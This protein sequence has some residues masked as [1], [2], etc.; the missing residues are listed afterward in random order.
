M[1]KTCLG[2]HALD[3]VQAPA[4]DKSMMRLLVITLAHSEF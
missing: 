1:R 4:H 2:L 3:W